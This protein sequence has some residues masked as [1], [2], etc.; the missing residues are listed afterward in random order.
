ME[1]DLD[2]DEWEWPVEWDELFVDPEEGRR[3]ALRLASASIGATANAAA[4]A[5][6]NRVTTSASTTSSTTYI[7]SHATVNH[8]TTVAHPSAATAAAAAAAAATAA[9][10][11]AATNAD[12]PST[13]AAEEGESERAMAHWQR[14]LLL[15]RTQLTLRAEE[16]TLLRVLLGALPECVVPLLP[17]LPSIISELD[18]LRYR[19]AKTAIARPAE[20]EAYPLI[21]LPREARVRLRAVASAL[22]ET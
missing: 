7:A 19:G 11:A 12:E 22:M 18:M 2:S 1:E 13:D 10:A 4:N 14:R 21:A 8:A 9:A 5:A 17:E 16:E 6:P 20:V 3:T 15:R